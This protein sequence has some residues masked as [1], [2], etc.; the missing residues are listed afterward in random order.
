M[1]VGDKSATAIE[2]LSGFIVADDRQLNEL[3]T[4][5]RMIEYSLD[6]ALAG[7]GAP[8]IGANVHAP[9][10]AFVGLFRAGLDAKAGDTDKSRFEEGAEDVRLRE[11]LLKVVQRLRALLLEG[12]A[13]GFRRQS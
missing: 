3:D 2:S 11:S 5:A 1:P 7:A 9:Q 6:K 4:F 13:E 12:A 8:R 10:K